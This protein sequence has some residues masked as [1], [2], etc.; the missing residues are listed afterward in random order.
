LTRDRNGSGG[1]PPPR[2]L[3]A[4]AAE[5]PTRALTVAGAPPHD[6]EAEASV[7]SAVLISPTV[8]DELRDVL[9]P[10]D[11]F[12]GAHRTL[13]E[14]LLELDAAGTKIDTVTVPSALRA[15]NQLHAVGGPA[16]IAE[17]VD[18]TPSVANVLEHAQLIRRLGALRRMLAGLH[19]LN[20]IGRA[21]ETRGDVDGYLQRCEAQVFAASATAVATNSASSAREMMGEALIALDPSRPRE[22]SG[23]STGLTPVDELTLGFKAKELWVLA[24]RPGMGKSALALQMA[25]NVAESGRHA[26]VFSAEMT[27]AE[28]SE[29]MLTADSGV[30]YSLIQ[31]R[32]LSMAHWGK[33]TDSIARLAR[34]PLKV[35]DDHALTPA[36]IRSRLRRHAA[37]LRKSHTGRLGLVV[38]DYVQLLSDGMPS[39]KRDGNRNDELERISRALK[40]LAGE[41]DV[42]ILALAQLSRA[43]ADRRPTLT[44]IRG[45]GAFEQDADKVLFVHRDDDARGEAE[46][47]LGK[48]RNVGRGVVSVGWQPW[49]VRFT[50]PGLGAQAGLAFDRYGED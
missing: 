5:Q 38:I 50:E 33:V 41:F 44:D 21:P 42:T 15:K 11:F 27:R 26:V 40:L 23:I 28:L 24:A 34:L 20:A 22:P 13:F 2:A 30:P 8:L 19:E 16:F 1:Q 4:P 49:C 32:E 45:S 36:R 48:G 6:A 43:G 46:L 17:I 7:L 25:V 29:R 39:G 9:E 35:D 12:V 47:I 37:A 3:P 31:K 18:A 10:R 14:V